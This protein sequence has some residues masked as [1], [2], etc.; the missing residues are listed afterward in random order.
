M[1]TFFSDTPRALA[2]DGTTVYVAAFLSGNQTATVNETLVP[3]GFVS[4]CGGGG[5]GNGVPGP[6]VEHRQRSGARRPA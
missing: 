5:A 6:S 4:S 1:L 2:T 3:D